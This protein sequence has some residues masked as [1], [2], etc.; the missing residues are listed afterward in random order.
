MTCAL[1]LHYSQSECSALKQMHTTL[2]ETRS[3]D[4]F[5]S[6]GDVFF[7]TTVCFFLRITLVVEGLND[8]SAASEP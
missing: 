2:T 7:L 5:R 3:S 6:T 4:V 8:V 1:F